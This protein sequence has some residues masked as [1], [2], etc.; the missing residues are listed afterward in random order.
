MGALKLDSKADKAALAAATA[1][2]IV[3]A[4]PAK[5]VTFVD[6]TSVTSRKGT[7][8]VYETGLAKGEA[9]FR[10]DALVKI[11]PDEY[12]QLNES[13]IGK[14]IRGGGKIPGI[15]AIDTKTPVARKT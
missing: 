9:R 14:V 12:F 5:T 7:D 15:R 2:P 10:D 11:I 6:G 8:W 4:G 3:V 1:V 13:K